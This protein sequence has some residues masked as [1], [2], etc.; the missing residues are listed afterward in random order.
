[1][2]PANR[3]D[4]DALSDV[5]AHHQV[6]APHA[7][8]V[9]GAEWTPG[10]VASAS[11][12]RWRG[13]LAG[14][15][16]RSPLL[17]FADDPETR[18]DLST[19]HPGGLARFITGAATP[20]SQLI[21]DE[22]ALR[23]ARVAADN[24]AAKGLELASDR[25]IESIQL[26]IALA[27]WS[28]DGVHYCAPVLLRPLRI[29]RHGRDFE[30]K[31]SGQPRLNPA[32][33]AAII[34]QFRVALDADT[35][36]RLTQADGTFKPNA[37]IDQLRALLGHVP[38]F[39]VTPRLV[40]SSFAEV[41]SALVDDI[42]ELEHPVLDAVAGNPTA[43][44]GLRAV[45]DV[46][47]IDPDEREPA[48]DTL[49]LDADSEQERVVAHIAGGNSLVV[50]AMPGTGATQT[51]VNAVGALLAR[52][53]RVLVV[54]ARRASLRA[55]TQRFGQIGLPSLAVSPG[56]LRRDL[57]RAIG[58]NEKAAKPA[59]REVDE[60]LLRLRGVIRSY[61]DELTRPDSTLGISALDCVTELS[62]LALLPTPPSTTARLSRTAVERLAADRSPAVATMVEAARLGEFRYGPGDSPWYG[63]DFESGEAALRAQQIA[64]RLR[65][66]ELP[67]LLVRAQELISTT[68]MRPFQS[69]AELGVYLRLLL[70]VRETLDRFSPAVFDRSLGELISATAS[71][72][73]APEMSSANRRRLKSLAR[74]YVRPGVHMPD[75]HEALVRVQQ[76]RTLWQRFVTVGITP[77]VPVGISDVH[78]AWQQVVA[79]LEVLDG[80][81]GH[82]ARE[83]QLVSWPIEDLSRLLGSLAQDSDALHNLHERSELTASLRA[84]ELDPLL[85]D[86]ATRH[87]PEEQVAA[88]LELAWWRSA[89]DSLL[90]Q[91]RSL[92]GAGHEVLERLEHDFRLVD[93]AHSSGNAQL[94]GWQ[95]A[96]SWKLGLVDWPD[97]A[98]ELKWMLAG[99]QVTSAELSAR[100]PHLTRAI[101]PV[102]VASPYE[103]PEIADSIHFDAVVLL[104]AAAIS[105]AESVGAIRRGRQIVAFGDPATQT[106]TPFDIAVLPRD[107]REHHAADRAEP[108]EDDSVLAV[109]A[110]FLPTMTLTRS[111]RAGGEDL[112]ELV[113]RRFYGGQIDALPWAGSFLGHPSLLLD[114][115]ANGQGMPDAVTGA[116]ESVDAEVDRVVELVTQHAE[117]RPRESL[118]VVTASEKHAVRVM[119][120]VLAAS[121]R[122][123]ALTEFLL[124]HE[125]E[126]FDVA[127]I[128][129]AAAQS[130]D[131]VIFSIG[132]GRTPHGRVLNDFGVLS[133]PGS[134]RLVA[135]AMTRAR[136]ALTIVSCFTAG[137]VDRDR[138]EHGAAALV[139][140]LAETAARRTQEHLP[141]DRD[142]M[143]VDLARRLEARGLRV[144]LGHSGKLGLVCANGGACFVVDT[145]SV[146]VGRSLREALRFRPELLRRLGWHYARVH[147]FE[148]FSDPDA[149][150]DRIALQA[151]IQ[152]VQ[153]TEEIPALV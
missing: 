57:I 37:I 116:V 60:A 98:A 54:G 33:A 38:G 112:V 89:L 127:T 140:V 128:A 12:R 41:S 17:H 111:Y 74:E 106:P 108:A 131:R 85:T 20:L 117:T 132:F 121:A 47:D 21:R 51:I 102:W 99:G 124:G 141:D 125:A 148:L 34:Q 52:N 79:D 43:R 92:L 48:A 144:A 30:I 8:A 67:R 137:H 123:P 49:L 120:A 24:V 71:R 18:I 28:S 25:G 50:R 70:G 3:S 119:Q 1:M 39:S 77:K 130:R 145:D 147:A 26:G 64:K 56:T 81:L 80:P 42:A 96:E 103:V 75:L 10:N 151:G 6:T 93:E 44:S 100:S 16:G 13:E 104:D 27:R 29:R 150:A 86:L 15:G 135:V 69:I 83:Q 23:A 19:T 122:R 101:A 84:W 7:I 146:L 36:V 107:D 90:Q 31:L 4:D 35:F 115:V 94:L 66:E 87:V 134:E 138:L 91:D 45:A 55:I 82:R 62:R 143:L 2:W 126:P 153:L 152:P 88:E 73:D 63:A 32:F 40:V 110:G 72:R 22:L 95:L 58:R 136:R 133:Q 68:H 76:Q 149:V 53:Q 61:R 142:P 14:A 59:L 118:M 109:L 139:R 129:Q 46:A 105:M 113:N 5:P 11:W 78:V 9:G 65:G 114:H 97:E